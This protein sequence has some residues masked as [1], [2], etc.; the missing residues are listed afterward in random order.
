MDGGQRVWAPH[1][2]E[3]YQLGEIVDVGADTLTVEPL[4]KSE[5]VFMLRCGMPNLCRLQ[6]TASLLEFINLHLLRLI[7]YDQLCVP[8]AY[9]NELRSIKIFY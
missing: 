4:N 2:L 6:F 5:Q 7:E 9:V 1:P 3:G 8:Q